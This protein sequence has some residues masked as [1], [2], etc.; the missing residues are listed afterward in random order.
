MLQTSRLLR[1]QKTAL[2]TIHCVIA[3]GRTPASL[4]LVIGSPRPLS[5]S[6][7][8]LVTPEDKNDIYRSDKVQAAV[9]HNFP[10][11]IEH[12]DRGLFRRVGYGL[13]A[14]SGLSWTSIAVTMSTAATMPAGGMLVF[15]TLLS[16]FSA[17]YWY[18]GLR[19][20]N[21]RSHAIRRNYPVLG[22]MRYIFEMIRP[23]LRQYIVEGDDEGKP[24]D[25][26]HRSVIYQRAKNVNDTLP[27]GTRRNVY[28]QHH[29]WACHSMWPLTMED[30][31][32]DPPEKQ[33]TT[34]GCAQFGTTQPYS[35]SVLNISGMSYGAISGNA[36]LALNQGARLAGCF[37]NTGEGGVSRFHIA[38]GG[39]IVWNVGT[40]Y[41]GCGINAPAPNSGGSH[42]HQRL[43]NADLMRETLANAQG[44]IRMIE[45]KLSQGAKPGHG[46]LLPRAKITREIAEARK[47][48]FPP[49]ADCHSPARHSAFASPLELMEFIHQV[50]QVAQ[51]IPVGIKLCVGDPRDV[52]ALCRAMVET[53]MGPD[54]ITVDGAEGGTGAAPGELSNSVG[55]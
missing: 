46:G 38:G 24:F 22:N 35:A 3:S 2:R 47:L 16:G 42:S 45:I 5:T 14:V 1:Y 18:I 44:R 51:G 6:T 49:T 25:R 20:I 32:M 21:Q 31:T 13:I 10:D 43:F 11:F 23:E 17:S 26:A 39:D 54:F 55:M 15:S 27:F 19:D 29:E 28:A 34:V 50:R 12:W 52:A 33:R 30:G 37:Q 8:P 4:R 53:G 9:A 7:R 36:I 48:A 41:F 40:G